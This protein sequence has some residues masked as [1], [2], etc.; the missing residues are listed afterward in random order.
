MSTAVKLLEGAA[1]VVVG[2]GV[3]ELFPWPQVSMSGWAG[4]EMQSAQSNCKQKKGI[5][6][7]V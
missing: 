2:P 1:V 6:V 4:P 3:V 5:I 7:P